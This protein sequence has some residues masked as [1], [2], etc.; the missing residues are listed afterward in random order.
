MDS[1]TE[2]SIIIL[3]NLS[4]ISF[5]IYAIYLLYIF[6]KA[7]TAGF[8]L[9]DAGDKIITITVVVILMNVAIIMR[10]NVIERLY[11]DKNGTIEQKPLIEIN[12]SK[13]RQDF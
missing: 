13:E 2:S 10:N 5:C 11:N 1:V 12:K 8:S 3:K 9:S 4:L 7:G 6:F